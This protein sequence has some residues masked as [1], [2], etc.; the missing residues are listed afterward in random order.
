MAFRL[1]DVRLWDS[2]PNL[3]LVAHNNREWVV[4]G[5][6]KVPLTASYTLASLAK[7]DVAPFLRF[8]GQL[9]RVSLVAETGDVGVRRLMGEDPTRRVAAVNFA[10]ARQAGG[11][12]RVG[13]TAK[14]ER[15]CYA[16]P[17]MIASLEAAKY[18]FDFWNE[19][20]YTPDLQITRDSTDFYAP[21]PRN[22]WAT[23]SVITAAAPDLRPGTGDTWS[24]PKM[25]RLIDGIF[26][27][28]LLCD[29]LP[30]CT[31]QTGAFGSGAFVNPPELIAPLMCAAI[32][33]FRPYYRDIVVSIPDATSTNYRVYEQTLLAYNLINAK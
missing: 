18:P 28:P 7:V 14:E 8:S 24:A 9:A 6:V 27:A 26:R 23:Y 16:T 12:Y 10:N 13:C 20:K 11:G 15:D 31:L 32:K 17:A 21:L 22:R 5:H 3:A 30:V 1:L 2:Q 4:G 29:R 25:E 19:L 33:A